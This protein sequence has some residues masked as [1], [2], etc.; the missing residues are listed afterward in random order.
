M[1]ES[2]PSNTLYRF[3]GGGVQ[4][5]RSCQLCTKFFNG[6]APEKS[7]TKHKWLDDDESYRG[8]YDIRRLEWSAAA[9]YHLCNLIFGQVNPSNLKELR[10]DLDKGY[11]PRED[12]IAVRIVSHTKRARMVIGAGSV[13]RT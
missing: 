5:D 8:H 1:T 13:D 7:W 2:S 4:F 12:Q 11:V 10:E 6:E 3:S 9:G